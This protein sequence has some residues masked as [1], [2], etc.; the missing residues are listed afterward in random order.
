MITEKIIFEESDGVARLTLNRPDQGNA[1]D[2]EMMRGIEESLDELNEKRRSRVLVIR[3]EG[4]DFCTRLD[5]GKQG[6][7]VK[8]LHEHYDQVARVNHL[9]RSF[10][11]VSLT[12]VQGKRLASALASRPKAI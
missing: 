5:L 6:G 7:G 12:L 2:L 3:G 11:G 10:P 9:F 8:E 1:V 4:E